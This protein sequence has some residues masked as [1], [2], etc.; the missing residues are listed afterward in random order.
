MTPIMYSESD[1]LE[2]ICQQI[3]LN[4]ELL[5]RIDAKLNL[6][7]AK[8]VSPF[9][10]VKE[11]AVRLHYANAE[12]LKDEIRRGEIPTQFIRWKTGPTGQRRR[13]FMDV[14]GYISHLRHKG[15]H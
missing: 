6:K 1:C 4:T 5:Q 3:A 9:I 10:P 12:L 8:A 2:V 13:Y 7:P 15:S 14:D 11:A